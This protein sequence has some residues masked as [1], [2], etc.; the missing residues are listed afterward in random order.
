MGREVASRTF[1]G[2]STSPAQPNQGL[3]RADKHRL[4][5][6]RTPSVYN[7]DGVP[8]ILRMGNDTKWPRALRRVNAHGPFLAQVA[9][10]G[11]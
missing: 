4:S 1:E 11:S 2:A 5:Q 9:R 3:H 7:R 10:L 6:E 8:V